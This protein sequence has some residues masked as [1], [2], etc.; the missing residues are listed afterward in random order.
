[1]VRAG[2]PRHE[3]CRL[4]FGAR[5]YIRFV[6]LLCAGPGDTF[7]PPAPAVDMERETLTEKLLHHARL[8]ANGASPKRW[9]FVL[10]GVYG[11]G[12]NWA[13]VARR[14]VQAKPEWGALL[15]DLR[16]HGASQ[17]F[18]PPH[19]VAA[20]AADLG[21]LARHLAISVDGVL[22]HSF[23]GK[24]AL[25][26]TRQAESP[27][28]Q[29][30]VIDSTPEAKPPGGSA[31]EMLSSVRALPDEF[32]SRQEAVHGLEQA[33]VAKP[34]AQWMATNLERTDSHYRWR[35]D[36]D[37]MQALLVDFFDTD[38][39]AVI[40]DPPAG[41]QVHVVKAEESSVLSESACQRIE[42][43]GKATGRVYLHRVAGGHW[44]N[45]DNPDALL[46]LLNQFL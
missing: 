33:G 12:R 43:A 7:G 27:P 6:R 36:I 26:Y 1:M 29:L 25:E 10:H 20:A 32:A 24:V 40:E 42:D 44:V 9:L 3:G 19:T 38:S 34:V 45:A 4:V 30:W 11:A 21:V 39:W 37:A 14:A 15:I 31:W 16:Q 28:E 13:S 23:G 17:D 46:A 22:G 18:P 41:I 5:S 2:A 35:F 8:S